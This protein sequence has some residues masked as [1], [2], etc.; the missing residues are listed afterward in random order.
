[1]NK[2]LPDK[3]EPAASSHVVSG[4]E[5]VAAEVEP[6]PAGNEVDESDECLAVTSVSA[7]GFVPMGWIGQWLMESILNLKNSDGWPTEG[8]YQLHWGRMVLAQKRRG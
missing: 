3:P 5:V 4:A 1:M 2:R 7:P 6:L 8:M